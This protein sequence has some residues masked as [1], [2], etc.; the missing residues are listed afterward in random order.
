MKVEVDVLGS[1]SLINL[2]VS[3]DVKHHVYYIAKSE[4]AVRLVSKWKGLGSIPLR[5]SFLL[6]K[7]VICGHCRVTWSITSY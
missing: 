4:L 6:K 1:P 2:M 7:I 3:V 5:L